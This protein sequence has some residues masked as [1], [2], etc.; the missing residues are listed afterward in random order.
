MPELRISK[1][2]QRRNVTNLGGKRPLDD[3]LAHVVLLR[4]HEQLPNLGRP[5]GP[6][7][8]GLGVVGK[9]GDLLQICH[10]KYTK[11]GSITK[12]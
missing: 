12:I 3:V 7:P 2:F 10:V 4:Q 6:E 11:L 9:A 8:A 1:L 5:L